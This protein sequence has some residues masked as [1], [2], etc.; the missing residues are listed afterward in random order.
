SSIAADQ[1]RTTERP[2]TPPPG[3]APTSTRCWQIARRTPPRRPRWGAR[4]SGGSSGR[5][6]VGR[7]WR[8]PRARH[9]ASRTPPP[10]A[11]SPTL[12]ALS[13]AVA[14][15]HGTQIAARRAVGA[16]QRSLDL[17]QTIHVAAYARGGVAEDEG[18]GQ[19]HDRVAERRRVHRRLVGAG[20]HLL[21]DESRDHGD[22]PRLH[23]PAGGGDHAQRRVALALD[24]PPQRGARR[25]AAVE[26][27]EG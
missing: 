2:P 6:C 27:V 11:P 7:R 14:R 3:C 10:P 19:T 22:D 8:A 13:L 9:P 1:Q 5:P 24:E 15:A 16:E 12:P 21:S 23:A 26:P 4:S 18:L 17:A 25:D 20:A